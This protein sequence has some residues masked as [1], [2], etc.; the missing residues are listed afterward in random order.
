M[1]TALICGAGGFIGSHMV[2]RLKERVL[3]C[4]GRKYCRPQQERPEGDI[5]YRYHENS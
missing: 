5:Y 1:K 3:G 4:A 2:K